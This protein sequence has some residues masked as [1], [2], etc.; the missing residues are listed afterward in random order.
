LPGSHTHDE[1]L[2]DLADRGQIWDPVKPAYYYKYDPQE[3]KFAAADPETTPI[4]WLY[5]NGQWG[6]KQ[7]PD[8]DPRQ[9]VV[10]YFGLKKVTDG[11]NGPQFKHLVRKG[12]MPDQRPRDPLLKKLVRWYLSMYGCCLKGHHPWAV[13]ISIVLVLAVLIGL[14]VFAVRKLKPQARSWIRWRRG[15][16][17]S[18]KQGISRLEHEDVQLG[19]LGSEATDEEV[20]YRYPE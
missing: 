17:A 16:F 6:D 8:S 12:L 15:W 1:A 5:F 11:P 7:Y 20:R 10:P 9:K 19:L 3:Q 14:S 4:D 13:V 18:K 2:I